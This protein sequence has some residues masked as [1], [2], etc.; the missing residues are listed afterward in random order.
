V[1][2]VEEAHRSTS[3][4]IIG[5]IAMK[6]RRKLRWN[7]ESEQFIDD[8]EANAMLARPSGLRMGSST[9]SRRH[10]IFVGQRAV[11]SPGC[12]RN[13]ASRELEL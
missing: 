1:T 6:L 10:R 4:C 5:W 7:P 11:L 9:S 8:T 13:R 2:T 12:R 3:G